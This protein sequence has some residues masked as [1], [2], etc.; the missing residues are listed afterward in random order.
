MYSNNNN[1]G[2]N[3][4]GFGSNQGSSQG[5]SRV[6]ITNDRFGNPQQIKT[7]YQAI[8]KKNG[9][10]LLDGC[11]KAYFEL[12]GKLY[13]VETS[14]RNKETKNGNPAIWMRVTQVRKQQNQTM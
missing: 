7:A 2:N 1:Y 6:R 14:P 8:D 4:G 13:K 3:S 5:N 9:G 11:Y 10:Q 12:G